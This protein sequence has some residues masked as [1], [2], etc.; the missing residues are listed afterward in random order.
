MTATAGG[1]TRPGNITGQSSNALGDA[2]G[3]S[4]PPYLRDMGR[5]EGTEMT[6]PA[7]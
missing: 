1:G 6:N 2:V 4:K 5:F 3:G 7:G